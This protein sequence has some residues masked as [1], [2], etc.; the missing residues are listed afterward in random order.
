MT[1]KKQITKPT[2]NAPLTQ[3]ELKLAFHD[4]WRDL[5]AAIGKELAKMNA[6]E[7]PI[8]ASNVSAVTKFLELTQSTALDTRSIIE[9]PQYN[10]GPLPQFDDTDDEWQK[11]PSSKR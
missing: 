8:T 7:T 4:K 1:T 6:D 2:S 5:R 3:A 10:R 9:P 11:L